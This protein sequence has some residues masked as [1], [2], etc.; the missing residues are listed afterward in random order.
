[1][2]SSCTDSTRAYFYGPTLDL[3]SPDEWKHR[4]IDVFVTYDGKRAADIAVSRYAVRHL[5]A[6]EVCTPFS[7]GR[8][9]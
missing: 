7:R 4:P 9:Y 1:M 3:E 5:V 6:A 2:V 8:L